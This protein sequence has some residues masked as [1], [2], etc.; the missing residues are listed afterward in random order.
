MTAVFANARRLLSSAIA[1][2]LGVAFVTAALLLGDALNQTMR[3]AAAGTVRD[4]QVVV[5]GT[6]DLPVPDAFADAVTGVPAVTG[7]RRDIAASGEYHH[8]RGREF[9]IIQPTPML[10]E[11][12]RLVSGRLP[13][14]AGEVALSDVVASRGIQLD[15]DLPLTVFAE[16]EQRVTLRVV[17]VVKP[18]FDTTP[19]PGQ[20]L[21]FVPG[22]QVSAWNTDDG[23]RA[24]YITGA[25]EPDALR[26]AV[27]G[28]PGASGLEVATAPDFVEQQVDKFTGSSQMIVGLVLG[29]AAVA[30]FVSALVIAN[31][32]SILV[33]QRTRQLALLRCVGALRGQV[34]GQVL[35]EALVL[36]VVASLAG[37]LL[38]GG[39][40]LGLVELSAGSF[41]TLT[42]LVANPVSLAVPLVVGVLITVLA[43]LMPARAATRIPP[44]AALRTGQVAAAARPGRLGVLAG[45]LLLV[46]GTAG[47]AWL[48]GQAELVPAMGFGAISFL[49]VLLLLGALIPAVAR[50]L[51]PLWAAA[52]GVPGELAADNAVRNPKRAAATAGALLVGV[53]L[54][55]M[56]SVGATS[57]EASVVSDLEGRYPIDLQIGAV[58]ATQLDRVDA[59]VSALPEVASTAV[60]RTGQVGVRS[61]EFTDDSVTLLALDPA[62]RSVARNPAFG[63]GLDAGT[64]TV[65][66][67]WKLPE[68]APVEVTG[69]SGTLTLKAVTGARNSDPVLVTPASMDAVAADAVPS[70]ILRFAPGDVYDAASVVSGAVEAVAPDA[71]LGG[72]APPRQEIK[73]VIDMLLGIVVG[74]LAIAVVIALVGIGN[75]LSL[76]VLERRPE[77]ALLRATGLTRA[78]L[79]RMI[80]LEAVLLA[81]VATVLGVGLGIGY[82][83]AAS[84]ALLGQAGAK[85]LV[86]IPW[87]RL[88]IVAAV[89][90]L[91][92]LAASVLPAIR[93]SKVPPAAAL[94]VE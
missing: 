78:Q 88:A 59:T 14:A 92:G 52:G 55:T 16:D 54:I 64:I 30:V 46:V 17:G 72:A 40:A 37:L 58:E 2:V 24:L 29:F 44:L 66:P 8:A 65:P 74:L 39:L 94:T 36:G 35:R 89:A 27:R 48:S 45:V 32:F 4:A 26:D 77:S 18:G 33:A 7:V 62:D 15:G 49:G 68:G 80:G 50:V 28:L 31:T 70:L 43:A 5:K 19:M 53:T 1:I 60:V 21:L 75:T 87:G 63:Q 90:V 38:G 12:T 81:V 93:G 61:G 67:R 11:T 57:G 6:D 51:A 9:V 3:D 41:L 91:A 22:E 69:P 13:A 86:V 76:S 71:E 83:I 82:G 25:P 34:F 79:R 85:V 20:P 23:S 47:L 42:R 84:H 10:S 73:G 56:M